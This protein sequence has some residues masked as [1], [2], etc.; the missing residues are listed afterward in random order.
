MA[1]GGRRKA[2]PIDDNRE[3]GTEGRRRK[4]IRYAL[5]AG[6]LLLS[7]CGNAG[8]C[9]QR[10]ENSSWAE[11]GGVEGICR[12]CFQPPNRERSP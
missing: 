12:G 5:I 4:A 10:S 8:V 6:G 7:C 3:R 1:G 9:P 2:A 11:R